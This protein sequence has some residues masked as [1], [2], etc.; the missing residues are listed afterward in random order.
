AQC[1]LRCG[2][3]N[4]TDRRPPLRR[5]RA[6]NPHQRS[7]RVG[8]GPAPRNPTAGTFPRVRVRCYVRARLIRLYRRR[9][10]VIVN[11]AVCLFALASVAEQ[12]TSVRPLGKRLPDRGLH[13][14]GTAP[15]TSS[16]AL[17]A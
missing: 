10:T 7:S 13:D 14:A 1:H 3:L 17:T 16:W 12:V 4:F 8:G 5:F 11:L 6:A 9:F 15:S 2:P